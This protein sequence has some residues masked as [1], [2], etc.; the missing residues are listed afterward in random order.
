MESATRTRDLSTAGPAGGGSR[1][2]RLGTIL[3]RNEVVKMWR[4]PATLVTLGFFTV[5]ALLNYGARWYMARQNAS[6]SFALPDAWPAVIAGM[7][8]PALIFGSLLL[9]LLVASEFSWR[10][11]RQNVIDGLSKEAWFTGKLLLI[12]L[13]AIVVLSLKLIVGGGLA[14]AGTDL[15]AAGSILPGRHHISALGGIGLAFLGYGSL[16]LTVAL[17][18]RGAGASIGVWFL[19]AAVIERLLMAGLRRLGDVSGEAARWLPVNVFNQLASYPQ[20]DPAIRDRLTRATAES[21]ESLA[22]VW[23]W[24]ALLPAAVGWI[25]LFVGVSFVVF[26]RRDL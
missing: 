17:A 6:T 10:T 22:A 12:P 13:L 8:Q 2:R 24:G 3:L 18:A 26:R 9:I 19:Y 23:S 4:R 14:L 16:A 15:A 5:L 7:A 21:G 1:H 11:A 20:H 25:A